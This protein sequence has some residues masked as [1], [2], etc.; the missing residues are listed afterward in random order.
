MVG[1]RS[2]SAPEGHVCLPSSL[3]PQDACNVAVVRSVALA[4]A[5]AVIC[6]PG[7]DAHV[8]FLLHNMD[9]MTTALTGS[10]ACCQAGDQV[11]FH[12]IYLFA[13]P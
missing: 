2:F 3:L 8:N 10:R 11:R 9:A 4:S 7:T 6:H 13:Y 12:G 5:R 1:V